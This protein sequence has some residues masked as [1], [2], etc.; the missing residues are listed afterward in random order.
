MNSIIENMK[1]LTERQR[2]LITRFTNRLLKRLP[3]AHTIIMTRR[4]GLKTAS[5]MTD[6][7]VIVFMSDDGVSDDGVSDDGVSDDGV[8][9]GGVCDDGE[10]VSNDEE[11]NC[12]CKC[13]SAG[14]RAGVR[15]SVHKSRKSKLSI[16]KIYTAEDESCRVCH[17]Q[18]DYI[19]SS[20][21][22]DTEEVAE[23]LTYRFPDIYERT[24]QS[25]LECLTKHLMFFV[26]KESMNV[27]TVNS[28]EMAKMNLLYYQIY[29][30]YLCKTG[31]VL[32]S[33]DTQ[34]IVTLH[35]R[36]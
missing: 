18:L 1:N 23:A 20:R 12:L 36:V 26:K 7:E 5:V 22:V 11:R 3:T 17:P 10:G 2:R 34:P 33:R 32:Y 27:T 6:Y 4:P 24:H 31:Y 8:S 15:D 14:V 25:Y 28:T 9:D 21:L 29:M 16:S 19:Q 35:T 30:I 13:V